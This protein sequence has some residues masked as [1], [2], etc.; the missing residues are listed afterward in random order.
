MR[1][2]VVMLI[3]TMIL[4]TG[5]GVLRKDN[6]REMLQKLPD[7]G[8]EEFVYNRNTGPSSASITATNGIKEDAGMLVEA[9]EIVENFTFG[10][11]YL[12]VKNL[13][14]EDGRIEEGT[15]K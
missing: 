11:F 6:M 2:R 14:I 15:E 10:S 8:F 4:A 3:L 5:C 1:I 13:W 12:R 9:V 7:A